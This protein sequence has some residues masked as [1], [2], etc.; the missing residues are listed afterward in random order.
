MRAVS[1]TGITEQRTDRRRGF[2]GRRCLVDVI[3]V[4][5]GR[6]RRVPGDGDVAGGCCNIH[7]RIYLGDVGRNRFRA[8]VRIDRRHHV[9]IVPTARRRIGRCG[10]ARRQHRRIRHHGRQRPVVVAGAIE[11]ERRIF[12]NGV[13]I[14]Q[15]NRHHVGGLGKFQIVQILF[16]VRR[17]QR[18]DTRDRAARGPCREDCGIDRIAIDIRDRERRS[19]QRRNDKTSIVELRRP[20]TVDTRK[21]NPIAVGQ[22]IRR[23]PGDGI[24]RAE[25]RAGT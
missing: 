4:D 16:G 22:G 14:D 1:R 11:I 24:G 23:C 9:L 19:G 8:V 12:R 2:V 6:L 15:T 18:I 10:A 25:T 3:F 17:R 20:R 21:R 7:R 5:P 13:L